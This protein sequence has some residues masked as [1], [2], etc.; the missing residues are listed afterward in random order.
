MNW[1]AR[2]S[3]SGFVALVTLGRV[4]PAAAEE[5]PPGRVRN[6]QAHVAALIRAGV[7]RSATFRGLVERIDA[8]D[9]LVF[10][11]DGRC[12]HGVRACL[13]TSLTLAGPSRL[14]HIAVEVGRN[15]R[16]VISLIG[17]ELQHALEVLDEPGIRSTS[18]MFV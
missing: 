17:H 3:V 7:E 18:E 4:L 5:A 2:L 13:R 11:A 15:E 12:G 16:Q 14:L 6:Q 1:T 9:G 10:V 8:S